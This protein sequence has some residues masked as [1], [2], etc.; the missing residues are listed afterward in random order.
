MTDGNSDSE[1]NADSDTETDSTPTLGPQS[2][3]GDVSPCYRAYVER[4]DH[5]PDVCT[6]YSAVTAGSIEE[7]W[8]RAN[9]SAFVSRDDVR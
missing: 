3:G 9:G 1:T 2:D 5:R 7:T 4:N 6:I 8:I